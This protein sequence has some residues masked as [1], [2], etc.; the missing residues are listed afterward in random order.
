[1][2]TNL[3]SFEQYKKERRAKTLEE[4]ELTVSDAPDYDIVNGI[5]SFYLLDSK[6]CLLCFD[7]EPLIIER[8]HIIGRKHSQATIPVCANC[9]KRLSRLQSEWR[10]VWLQSDISTKDKEELGVI[11]LKDILKLFIENYSLD[12]ARKIVQEASKILTHRNED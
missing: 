3:Q 2:D 10:D 5:K 4:K 7:S 6:C 8:H 11:S 12:S 9:H 1:M